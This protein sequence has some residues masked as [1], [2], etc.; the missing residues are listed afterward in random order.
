MI[1]LLSFP[2]EQI[3]F[4]KGTYR[5]HDGEVVSY[6][7]KM[8]NVVVF[9]FHG[10]TVSTRV[11]VGSY[12]RRTSD[13]TPT[14]TLHHTVI[15]CVDFS[16]QHTLEDLCSQIQSFGFDTH[17]THD[18]IQQRVTESLNLLPSLAKRG[19]TDKT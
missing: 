7:A 14:K 2:R 8:A 13:L 11:P 15:D 19:V 6:T 1:E 10:R 4:H 17:T 3:R 18:L 9:D 16:I 5:D 12:H